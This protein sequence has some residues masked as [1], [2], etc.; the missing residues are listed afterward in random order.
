MSDEKTEG[1]RIFAKQYDDAKSED[2]RYKAAL[3]LAEALNNYYGKEYNDYPYVVVEDNVGLKSSVET[4]LGRTLTEDEYFEIRHCQG[5]YFNDKIYLVSGSIDTS[6]DFE[7]T[8]FHENVHREISSNFD[9]AYLENIYDEIE[10]SNPGLIEQTLADNYHSLNKSGKI[11][12]LISQSAEYLYNKGLRHLDLSKF[13]AGSSGINSINFNGAIATVFNNIT[14]KEYGRKED[15]NERTVQD[16]IRT[17]SNVS[18]ERNR[19]GTDKEISTAK[20]IRRKILSSDRLDNGSNQQTLSEYSRSAGLEGRSG[21]AENQSNTGREMPLFRTGMSVADYA[22]DVAAWNEEMRRGGDLETGRGVESSEEMRIF[23]KRYDDA[24]TGSERYQAALELAEALND[25]YGKEY[26]DYPYVVVEDVKDLE[27]ITGTPVSESDRV[28]IENAR[29]FYWNN[30]AYLISN[31]N[32]TSNEFINTWEHENAHREIERNYDDNYLANLYDTLNTDDEGVVER[33]LP[34]EYHSET[35]ADKINELLVRSLD[36]IKSK[37][38]DLTG[39]TQ[40]TYDTIHNLS[41]IKSIDF[42]GALVTLYNNIYN[43]PTNESKDNQAGRAYENRRKNYVEFSGSNSGTART[44]IRTNQN[45]A[46][47]TKRSRSKGA[48]GIARSGDGA[49][50]RFRTEGYDKEFK[51]IK[52][53]AVADGEGAGIRFRDKYYEINVRNFKAQIAIATSKY[54]ALKERRSAGK[55]SKAAFEDKEGVLIATIARL[56]KTLADYELQHAEDTADPAPVWNGQKPIG[57]WAQEK[58][59]WNVRESLRRGM[60]ETANEQRGIAEGIGKAEAD[61]DRLEFLRIELDERLGGWF[62][63]LAEGWQDNI[64]SVRIFFDMMK[65]QGLRISDFNNFYM[66]YTAIQGKNDAHLKDFGARFMKPVN[67]MVNQIL[68]KTKYSYR[69]IENYVMAKHG[70]ERNNYMKEEAEQVAA[71][72]GTKARIRDDYSGLYAIAAELYA[73]EKGISFDPKK[74]GEVEKIQALPSFKVQR[75]RVIG[76]FIQEFEDTVNSLELETKHAP[77]VQKGMSHIDA[78]WKTINAATHYSLDRLVQGGVESKKEI[79]DLKSRFKYYVPLRGHEI[80]AEKRWQYE[81][82]D[83]KNV[84]SKAIVQAKGRSTRAE[85]P[86]AYMIQTAQTSINKANRNMLNQ[87]MLRLARMDKT[88]MMS[89]SEGWYMLS[90]IDPITGKEIWTETEPEFVEDHAIRVEEISAWNEKMVELEAEGKAKRFRKGLDIGGLFIKPK[91]RK[92]HAISVYED[93]VLYQVYIN[94]NPRVAQAVNELSMEPEKIPWISPLTRFVSSM[95][96]SRSPQF[97]L[98]NGARDFVFAST[99]LPVKEGAKYMGQFL[100][101]YPKAMALLANDVTFKFGKEE[102]KMK[103]YLKEFKLNG[104]ETGYSHLLELHDIQKKLE[105]EQRGKNYYNPLTY[106]Q[107]IIDVIDTSNSVIENATRLATYI[108]LR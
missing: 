71:D 59:E 1:M 18:S 63:R 55:I 25:Y 26:D 97:M 107:M 99:I 88:G 87:T 69:D 31:N 4:V 80:E 91:Q 49:D 10:T 78:F 24:K 53:G 64:R 46:N 21:G 81:A 47:E 50:I 74:K 44:D 85:Y 5:I 102:T 56:K 13:S 58:A 12:E 84:V 103:R 68:G 67:K 22:R 93:G 20:E 7:N 42:T 45:Q 62:G 86:F 32:K 16:D 66:Q 65:E 70:I 104:G 98:T 36:Y 51:D 37:G 77:S 8:W 90:G 30:K 29:G 14:N 40:K 79:D 105:R 33:F 75:N 35:K 94:G 54:D 96:T 108:A 2:E 83:N 27:K 60:E 100:K 38:T 61:T 17:S 9:A 101:S 11:E 23:A 95:V 72:K 39:Y 52:E 43:N 57:E 73:A 76:E 34:E 48:E 41:E 15:N 89:V 28:I 19:S 82:P 3:E 106:G 6:T 92:Q